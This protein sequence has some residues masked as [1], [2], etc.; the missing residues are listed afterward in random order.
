MNVGVTSGGD[1]FGGSSVTFSDVLGDQQFNLYAA[2]ISQYRTLSFSYL[3]L[4]RRFNYAL[5][6]VLTDDVLLRQSRERLLRRVVHRRSRPGAGDAHDPRRNG[7]RHLAVQSLPARRAVRRVH[8]VPGAVQRPEPRSSC[9]DQYQ[10]EQ[11]GRQ[12]F[13][14]GNFVPLG[15]NFV[16]ETTVFREFGP[17]AGRTMRLGYEVLAEDGRRHAVA[18]DDGR[19][20]PLLPAHGQQRPAGASR[21]RLPQLGRRRR[22]SCTSAATPRCA[23]TTTWSS[24]AIASA[25]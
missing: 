21:A 8:A 22:T 10:Q 23:A 2:S 3:N 25:S 18:A 19:R 7:L 1:I 6:G 9:L 12:L 24:S 16:E 5:Q 4:A 14:S 17:L 15:V 20:R 11:F 13:R